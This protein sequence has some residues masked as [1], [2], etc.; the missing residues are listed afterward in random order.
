MDA[1]GRAL[2]GPGVL[3]ATGENATVDHPR[4]LAA[5]ENVLL[6]EGFEP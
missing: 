3:T 1:K 4:R 6:I 5:P 2:V